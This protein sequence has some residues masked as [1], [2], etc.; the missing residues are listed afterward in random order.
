[1]YEDA[2]RERESV[3]ARLARMDNERRQLIDS[4]EDG[5]KRARD[6]SKVCTL[7]CGRGPFSACLVHILLLTAQTIRQSPYHHLT[8]SSPPLPSPSTK[9]LALDCG[10]A[11]GPSEEREDRRSETAGS[12]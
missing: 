10:Q 12:S 5:E 7:M 1:M 9:C 2:V 8:L 4:K 11:A 3:V 6:L